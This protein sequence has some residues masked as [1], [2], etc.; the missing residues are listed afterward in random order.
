MEQRALQGK[1][2]IGLLRC[3]TH[4]QADTSIVDQRRVL[5]AFARDQGLVHVDDV[6]LGGVSGSLPG[7]RDDIPELIERKKRADDFD[8][9]LVQDTSRFSRA[10]IDHVHHLKYLL[11]SA[12]IRVLFATGRNADGWAGELET[13]F[14]AGVDQAHARSIS[15]GSARGS[16]S[17]I[18]DGRSP[19][20]RRPPYAI[21]RLYVNPDETPRHVIRNLPDRRQIQLNPETGEVIDHFDANEKSGIPNH[22]NKQKQERIVLIPGDDRCVET[23][24]RIYRRHYVD[25]L[26]SY[27]IA[28][29]L[30]T[31]GVPS[32]AGGK[33]NTNTIG[34]I[35]RNPIY[36]GRGVANRFTS[37]VY[38]MRADDRP[39]ALDID[40]SELCNR[41]RPVRKTRP[42]SDWRY[43]DHPQLA[44]LIEPEVREIAAEHQQAYLDGQASGHV[45]KPNR[46]RHRDTSYYL[47]GLLVS[48]QGN[49]PLTGHTSG[50]NKKIRYYRDREAYAKPD[51]DDVQRNLI[52][53]DPL[54]KAVLE[55]VKQTLLAL[56]DL[57]ERIER[58]VRAE[59]EATSQDN[60]QL[61]ELVKEREAIRGKL[62]LI[63]ERFDPEMQDLIDDEIGAL[64]AQLRSVNERISRCESVKPTDDKAIS[65]IVD[66]T[67]A[68]IHD[69]ATILTDAPPATLRQ[70]LNV[71]ISRLVVDLETRDVEL[72]ISLPSTINGEKLRMCLVEGLACKSYNETHQSCPAT[73]AAFCL[74][75]DK[76]SRRFQPTELPRDQTGAAA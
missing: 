17:S 46:N 72:E 67:V 57:R 13:S 2:Y 66:Q 15:F 74:E 69:L 51:G 25:N 24:R 27:R 8:V 34:K 68:A 52:P 16:M 64:K 32:P 47:S 48:K 49:R 59:L 71:L 20:C 45:P 28:K 42:A 26:G 4:G 3:S 7:A 73:I 35:L 43:Q 60:A 19:Y 61:D 11:N 54:E 55:T 39:V 56:P 29:E 22:Y 75:W 58:Q 50:N 53:A 70:L 31:E 6:V 30:N 18:L 36:L 10:G 37:A 63:L 65:E 76:K 41:K 5:E 21:D 23:L 12:G 62:K 40:P 14:N 1:R 44:E 9:L 38:H 33:W